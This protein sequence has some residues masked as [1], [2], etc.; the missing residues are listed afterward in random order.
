MKV[1]S[2]RLEPD[3]VRSFVEAAWPLRS[4]DR[5]W[6]PPARAGQMALLSERNPFF[7]RGDIGCFVAEDASGVLARC[8]AMVDRR[9]ANADGPVGMIGFYESTRDAVASRAV[10]DAALAWLKERGI[11]TVLGPMELS[12]WHGY[13]FMTRGFERDAFL[14]EPRN[15][16]WYPE[17]FQAAG[18]EPLARYRSWDLTLEHLQAM[19]AFADRAAAPAKMAEAGLHIAPLDL[20]RFDDQMAAV[21]ELLQEGFSDNPAYAPIPLPELLDIFGG[22]KPLVIPE[23][24]PVIWDRERRAAGFGYLFPDYADAVRRMNGGSGFFAKVRF[25]LARGACD[26]L[27]FNAMAVRKDHRHE[28]IVE[29]T[30]SGLLGF[31]LSNGFTRGI[32]ALAKEGPTFFDKTGEPSREY[33]LFRRAL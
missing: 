25:V 13:R 32:G 20:S 19:K 3:R 17:Q 6:V 10:I 24:L 31:A 1:E 7:Q 16:P 29:T 15:P 26:R 4:G 8:A 9:M 11:R 22:M 23:L 21:H 28:G 12:I 27:V 18:F 14:G 30:L 2:F 5:Q 33:A